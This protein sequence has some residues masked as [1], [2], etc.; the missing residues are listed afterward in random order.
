M[1]TGCNREFPL[2]ELI[3]ERARLA[4]E[5]ESLNASTAAE[6]VSSK[7]ELNAQRDKLEQQAADLAAR[8]EALAAGE[9]YSHTQ[10]FFGMQCQVLHNAGDHTG[11]RDVCL[12]TLLLTC[13]PVCMWCCAGE[14]ALKSAQLELQLQTRKQEAEMEMVQAKLQQQAEALVSNHT[15]SQRKL[16]T[17]MAEVE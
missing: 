2:Q 1:P 12:L 13:E 5:V 3:S 11:K 9:A 14:G 10:T 7:A 17:D 6:A 4:A 15:A 8:A 16:T